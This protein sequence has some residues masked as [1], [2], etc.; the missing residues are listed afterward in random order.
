MIMTSSLYVVLWRVWKIHQKRCYI[1]VHFSSTLTSILNLHLQKADKTTFP[2]IY[3]L[4]GNILNF[5]RSSQ[6]QYVIPPIQTNGTECAQTHT[7]AHTSENIISPVSLRSL[8]RYKNSLAN[9]IKVKVQ[10]LKDTCVF[11]LP[12]LRQQNVAF[13]IFFFKIRVW[14][15]SL[16][17]YFV[18]TP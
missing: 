6:I 2:T 17:P 11:S 1:F 12:L 13:Q 7:H 8:G 10:P 16:Y 5:S 15:G 3:C 9:K 14:P 4:Y 18:I